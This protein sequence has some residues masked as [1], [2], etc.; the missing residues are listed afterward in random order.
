MHLFIL[1]FF[2]NKM[3]VLPQKKLKILIYFFV[4]LLSF[5]V[6]CF[7]SSSSC[8]MRGLC[9]LNTTIWL[10]LFYYGG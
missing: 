10:A 1:F 5:C 8:A 7:L 3:V 2:L 4:F 9:C 6:A